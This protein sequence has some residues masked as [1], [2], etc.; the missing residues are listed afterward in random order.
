MDIVSIE[1][2][3]I[4]RDDT[5]MGIDIYPPVGTL[6]ESIGFS[7]RVHESLPIHD[8]GSLLEILLDSITR[9]HDD[10]LDNLVQGKWILEYHDITSSHHMLSLIVIVQIYSDGISIV[11][12]RL[13]THSPHIILM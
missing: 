3:D 11:Y 10:S 8:E 12:H 1:I 6:I 2:I 4:L 9:N 7:D 5:T 13:H